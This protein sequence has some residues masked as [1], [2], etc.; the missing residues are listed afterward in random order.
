[1]KLSCSYPPSPQAQNFSLPLKMKN[2]DFQS[3]LDRFSISFQILQIIFQITRYFSCAEDLGNNCLNS[4]EVFNLPN[5][6]YFEKSSK[7]FRNI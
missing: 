4:D 5:Y 6:F 1:M 7:Y 3:G 2:I